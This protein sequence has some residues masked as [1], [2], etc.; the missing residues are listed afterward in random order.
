MLFETAPVNRCFRFALLACLGFL[1]A[2][3]LG[4]LTVHLVNDSP[5][6]LDYPFGSLEES[7][8]SIRTPVYPALLRLVQAFG[9]LQWIPSVQ[10]IVHVLASW[11]LL[12]ELMRRGV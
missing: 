11:L 9:S 8:L 10:V 4:R 3:L 2:G 7:F 1:Y 12:E 6:Y 5:S